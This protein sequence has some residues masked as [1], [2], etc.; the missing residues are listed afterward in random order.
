MSER[1]AA[2]CPAHVEASKASDAEPPLLAG[3]PAI[4]AGAM[5]SAHKEERPCYLCARKVP[6]DVD[7]DAKGLM[8]K[9][10]FIE[11]RPLQ[12]IDLATHAA[13]LSSGVICCPQFSDSASKCQDVE[14]VGPC[15]EADL[16][17]AQA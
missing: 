11:D 1:A 4:E 2:F 15:S 16:I 10:N 7:L 9:L 13:L 14:E 12:N 17:M 3:A 6:A 8:W 5:W